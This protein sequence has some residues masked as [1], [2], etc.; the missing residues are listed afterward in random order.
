MEFLSPEWLAALLAI[1]LVDL[2]LA[3][4]NAIVIALAA[5]NLPPVWKKRAIIYG[6]A[7]AVVV[8]VLLAFFLSQ[9]LRLPGLGIVGGLALYVIAWRL[10]AN[11]PS[12]DKAGSSANSFWR[13][14][15]MIIAADTVMGLDNVL[16]IAGAARGDIWLII[17][18]LGLSVPIM[19]GGSVLILKFFERLSWLPYFGALLLAGI[20]GRIVLDDPWLTARLELPVLAEWAAILVVAVLVLVACHLKKKIDAKKV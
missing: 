11:P 15:G 8:R 10:L 17:I 14:M 2:L 5:R 3:G 12:A 18:G 13:A 4:D 9:L 20:A 16:A 7:G 6:T 1:V 19:M